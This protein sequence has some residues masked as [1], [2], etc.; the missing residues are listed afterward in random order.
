LEKRQVEEKRDS[1][2]N[3]KGKRGVK[4]IREETGVE[5]EKEKQDSIRLYEIR[6]SK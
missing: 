6:R 1:R 2:G 3:Q 5:E 4:N